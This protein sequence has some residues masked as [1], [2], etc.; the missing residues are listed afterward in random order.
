MRGNVQPDDRPLG[1]GQNS[2]PIFR[3]FWT[4]AHRIKFACAVVF[5]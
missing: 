1:V 5:V 3:R 4:K 2:G